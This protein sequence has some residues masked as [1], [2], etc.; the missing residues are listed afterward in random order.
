MTTIDLCRCMFLCLVLSSTTPWLRATSITITSATC[1]M[2]DSVTGYS[3]VSSERSCS[4]TRSFVY[5]GR[6]YSA[7][8]SA[9]AG[10]GSV[11]ITAIGN[12]DYLNNQYYAASASAVFDTY[13]TIISRGP[14]RPGL[15]VLSGTIEGGGVD[16]FNHGY[17]MFGDYKWETQGGSTLSPIPWL[18]RVPWPITLGVLIPIHLHGDTS[19]YGDSGSDNVVLGSNVKLTF[20]YSL[21]RPTE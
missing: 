11:S 14:V 19:G 18:A 3:T 1:S 6:T 13:D 17:I 15:A 21:L 7:V 5:Q 10:P 16:A 4:L 20:T 8:A 9:S 2:Y 12:A